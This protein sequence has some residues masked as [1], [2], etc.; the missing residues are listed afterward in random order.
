[1]TRT[2]KRHVFS[3]SKRISRKS[4]F[5]RRTRTRTRT[6]NRNK[7]GAMKGV[8]KGGNTIYGRG[9]GANCYDP[10]FS[11]FNTNALKLF[12]YNPFTKV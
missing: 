11:I 3:S 10:S 2:R 6:K 4:S 5:R 1:M 12:P 7:K 8:M 9:Y